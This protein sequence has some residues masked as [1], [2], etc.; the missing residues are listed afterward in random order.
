MELI[1]IYIDKYRTFEKCEISLSNKFRVKYTHDKRFLS[2][3]EIGAYTKIYPIHISNISGI[4]GKNASGK[5]SLLSLIGKKIDDRHRAHEIFAEEESDPHKKMDLFALE[6]SPGLESVKFSSSYFLLYFLGEDSDGFPLFIFE[7][8]TPQSYVDIFEKTTYL[9]EENGV[10]GEGLKYYSSTGWFAGV[11]KNKQDKNIFLGDTQRYL[12]GE[13]PIQNDIA[14]LNFSPN[15]Y[16][17]KIQFAHDNDE[18]SK[19]CLKRRTI[20]LQYVFWE[21]QLNFLCKQMNWSSK[22][23]MYFNECYTLSIEFASVMPSNLLVTN[24][25]KEFDNDDLVK[26]YRNFNIKSFNDWEKITLVFLNHYTWYLLTGYSNARD[27]S[28]DKKKQQLKQLL[29]IRTLSDSYSDIKDYYHGKIEFILSAYENKDLTIDE[30]LKVE[31]ALEQFL[32]HAE[33][34]GITY[35]YKRDNLLIEIRKK[36]DLSAVDFF[37]KEFVDLDMRKNL[38]K[39]D[40]VL[41][42]FLDISIQWLSDGERAYLSLYTAL[43]E[44]ISMYPNKK[45]YILL[46]DEIERS[47]HPDLCRCLVSELVDFL[48]QYPEKKFQIIIASHSPFIASDLLKGNIVCLNRDYG[49]SNILEMT[50]SP[51]AQNIHTILKTQFFLSGFLGEYSAKCI[52]LVLEGINCNK[53]EEV[54]QKA[55]Q[56]CVSENAH[57]NTKCFSSIEEVTQFFERIIQSIGE[58]LIRNELSRRMATA[59]WRNVDDQILYYRKKIAELEGKND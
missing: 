42:N 14:I 34:H 2:I 38:S 41:G 8:N 29:H 6:E 45:H 53:S 48:A 1:Y 9:K 3:K 46:L 55:N 22:S 32:Q 23:R 28:L 57:T 56:F 44:Q 39:E 16:K 43:D 27:I 11:F 33:A 10:W 49:H 15:A 5:S 20:S 26:D 51:F 30:F 13:H 24:G 54:I 25:E 18:E 19:I 21:S 52:S 7:T 36:S 47:M 17:H 59:V 40:S 50:E 58:P 4:L 35:S 31:S 37:F 12:D